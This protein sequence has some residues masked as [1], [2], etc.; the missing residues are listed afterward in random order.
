MPLDGTSAKV[1]DPT[2]GEQNGGLPTPFPDTTGD[3][4]RVVEQ[5]EGFLVVV[6]ESIGV[7]QVR[8]SP[9]EVVFHPEL[10]PDGQG[11]QVPVD[12]PVGVTHCVVD[13]G[14]VVESARLALS[15]VRRS[16]LGEGLPEALLGRRELAS[17]A[18]REAQP[19]EQ[20]DFEEDAP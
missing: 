19:I 9:D 1:V 14:E 6:E 17:I 20:A 16:S 12:G 8:Q 3:L 18:P 11:L 13:Q 15:L 10:A 4:E 2:D 5:V 7:G